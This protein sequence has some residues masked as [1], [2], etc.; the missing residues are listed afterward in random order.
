[1]RKRGLGTAVVAVLDAPVDA[2]DADRLREETPLN[3]AE[4]LF[5]RPAATFLACRLA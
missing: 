4:P 2:I 5:A 3:S 1:M